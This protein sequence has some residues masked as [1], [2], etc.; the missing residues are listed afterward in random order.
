MAAQFEDTVNKAADDGVVAGGAAIAVD[1]SGKLL[2]QKAFGK[3][4][5]GDDDKLFTVDSVMWIASCT[6]LMTSIAALQCVERG[7]LELD[8]PISAILPEWSEPQIIIGFDADN[9]VPKLRPATKFITLRHLLSH[10]S[11]MAYPLLNPLL[12][13]YCGQSL[14]TE[15][16][17]IK[18]QY[19]TPLI[20]EPGEGWEYGPGID[21]AGKMVER[22]NSGVKLGDIL[23]KNVWDP[24]GM[25]STTFHPLQRPEIMKR[26]VGRTRRTETGSLTK[27]ETEM[28]LVSELEDDFGGDGTYS[29]ARDFTK[30]LTSLLMND[31]VL[32]GPK[33]R[34]ELFKGQL[35]HPE[36]F[37][38]R[39]EDPVMGGFLAP[40]LPRDQDR[41][42]DYGCGGAVLVSAVEG[43]AGK[44][45]LY[46]SGL[47]NSFWFIDRE[48]GTCGFYGSWLLPPGDAPT[49]KLFTAFQRAAFAAV[50]KL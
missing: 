40:G 33:M 3:I 22:V 11:G 18:D 24:L 45:L 42:W 5:I 19:L 28:F 26:M 4:G 23:Q 41:R 9:K 50:A 39:A 49:G 20:Y 21:W 6:K 17:S 31:G 15:N 46:W 47:P 35:A 37:K 38:A 16:K 13:Q 14:G 12:S 1:K 32:L 30:I 8:G 34:E 43:Q 29:S 44:E 25:E 2:F 36:A 7:L 10:S 27:D 48:R